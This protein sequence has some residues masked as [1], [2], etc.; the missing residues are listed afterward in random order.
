MFPRH[1]WQRTYE[2]GQDDLFGDFYR[3]FLRDATQYDR[4][5]G[6]LSLRGLAS[7][8][9]GVDSL[10][11][12]DG[13][14]RVIAG[15][16]LRERERGVLFPDRDEVFPDWIES[17][18]RIIAELLDQGNLSIKVADVE[19]STGVFHSKLGIG[20][21]GNQN[22]I[23]FEGS[24]NETPSGWLR[25]YERFKIHRSWEQVEQEYVARDQQ[26][27]KTLWNDEHPYV[28]IYDLTDAEKADIINWK[29]NNNESLDTHIQTVSDGRPDNV[30]SEWELAEIA[31]I[32]GQTPGGI[33]LAEDVSTVTPWPHQRTIADT[34]VSLYPNNL[35]FCDEVGL[36]KTIEVGLTLSRLIHSGKVDTALLLVPASLVR[37]WQNELYD[38]FNIMGYYFDRRG[39]RNVLVG[40]L[41]DES[42]QVHELRGT[43]TAGTWENTPIGDFISNRDR[44]TVIIQSWHRARLTQNQR[45]VAP[46]HSEDIWDVTVVDEAHNA[47]GSHTNFYELLT[48]VENVSAC[49]YALTATPMQIDIGELYD[50]LRLCNL[51][52]SW[53]DRDSFQEFYRTQMILESALEMVGEDPAGFGSLYND[54][55]RVF[56][57]RYEEVFDST[58]STEE[59]K[60]RLRMF[61]QM[62][63]DHAELYPGYDAHIN[64]I[65]GSSGSNLSLNLSDRANIEK[66]LDTTERTFNTPGDLLYECSKE[67]WEAIVELS[68]EMNPVQSR[69]FRNT[70]SVLR[71]A[72]EEERLTETVPRRD[73]TT[74]EIELNSEMKSLFNQIEEYIRK[75]YQLSEEVL[76]DKERAAIGFVMTTYRQRLSSSLHGITES[77]K[78][79][80]ERLDGEI[81]NDS[82]LE[83]LA[84]S[85]DVSETDIEELL[86]TGRIDAY[87]PTEAEVVQLEKNQIDS[88]IDDLES[89][90]TDPKGRQLTQTLMT[91]HEKGDDKIVIFTQYTDTLEYIANKLTPVHSVGTYSGDGAQRYQNGEWQTV[92]KET[93]KNEFAEGDVGILVCTDSA[94][95][96]LN[97]QTG[98]VLINYDLPWNPMKVEQRI[99]RIDRIG[100]ENEVVKVINY[101]YEDGID[102]E[103]YER[104]DD[105][106]SLFDDVVGD[107]RPVL[108]GVETEINELALE[109]GSQADIET[110]VSKK[111]REAEELKSKVN[112]TGL[113][114]EE[115]QTFDDSSLSGW[116]NPIHPALPSVGSIDRTYEPVVNEDA[117][118]YLFTQSS[119]LEEAGWS[120]SA[121]RNH[122]RH[123]EYP[124]AIQDAYQLS[125]PEGFSNSRIMTVTTNATAQSTLRGS[126][127]IAV[128]FSS[129]LAREFPSLRLLLPGDPLFDHLLETIQSEMPELTQDSASLLCLSSTDHNILSVSDP[130]SM[131]TEVIAPVVN[132]ELTTV[133]I[134]TY[135]R[136]TANRILADWDL[137]LDEL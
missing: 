44:P 66:L 84:E 107:T 105:R 104:L 38:R 134:N 136:D 79:R 4:I 87:Q 3:P 55:E 96:G 108:A 46:E 49:L 117:I 103:I 132:D 73:V 14:V 65:T 135:T 9:E 35:L 120:F 67:G 25:N 15:A 42:E 127:S 20:Q 98:D 100:Q 71:R 82:E 6:Y 37:Q 32:A 21:D 27:F 102:K 5:A 112:A 58:L 45:H 64:K 119:T 92:G 85:T 40:P 81:D 2:T 131:D 95:E 74:K 69:I 123:R 17:Q 76:K 39:H 115:R 28:D 77:L 59:V 19:Q 24:V 56:Q 16:D 41:G 137:N 72:R 97:L 88:F 129:D 124:D 78:R 94:S 7:A 48:R 110:L 90:Q 52:E 99:G 22:I 34:A 70:R 128:T 1:N 10:L 125:T 109:G 50:L 23:S 106:L 68:G 36:G 80:R 113:T 91:L 57:R 118:E 13:Q 11:E 12:T 60:Q 75:T 86:G 31:S 63:S 29:T 33:H 51:P 18:L 116:S 8:L 53:D 43:R 26:T 61:A 122:E 126:D 83:Q 114:A 54:T 30:L 133:G 62:I 121:L 101:A 93:I 130:D 47:R 89:A 111:E